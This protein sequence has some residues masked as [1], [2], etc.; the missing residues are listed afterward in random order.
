MSHPHFQPFPDMDSILDEAV[1]HPPSDKM[2]FGSFENQTVFLVILY[3]FERMG[4]RGSSCVHREIGFFYKD[5]T[6][7]H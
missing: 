2:R 7:V 5:E 4:C 1:P 3:I 6:T